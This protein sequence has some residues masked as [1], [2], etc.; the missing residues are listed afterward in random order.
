MT[1][2]AARVDANHRELVMLLRE[3]GAYVI[4]TSHV[5]SGFP[6]CVVGWRGKWTLVEFKDGAK[7]PSRRKL[8]VDQIPLHAECQRRGLPLRVVTDRDEAL[9][10][11][12]ARM[13]A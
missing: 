6:D 4:D 3:L 8:T 7:S 13:G 10:L 9:E 11:L 1:R 12:G 5:G 2:Y